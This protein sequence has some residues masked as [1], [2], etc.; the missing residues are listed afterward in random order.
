MKS[1]HWIL[2]EEESQNQN[3]TG[4]WEETYNVAC[5]A[6]ANKDSYVHVRAGRNRRVMFQ[7]N[8]LCWRH[9]GPDEKWHV[10]VHTASEGQGWDSPSG[11]RHSGYWI[12]LSWIT[13]MEWLLKKPKRIIPNTIASLLSPPLLPQL[14]EYTDISDFSFAKLW[15]K[16][17]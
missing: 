5:N 2:L 4:F 14:A 7:S 11:P 17:K 3:K 15:L 13:N 1:L 6:S 12:Q 10:Q 16:R 8:P 9:R